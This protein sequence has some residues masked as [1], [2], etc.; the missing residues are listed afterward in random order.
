MNVRS[1]QAPQNTVGRY[2]IYG[3]FGGGVLGSV[4]GVLASG[5]NFFVWS[6]AQSIGVVAGLTMGMA[7]IG[8]FFAGLVVGD[9]AG[10]GA[11]AEGQKEMNSTVGGGSAADGADGGGVGD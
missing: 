11:S 8:Y 2:K 4:I 10:D 1:S 6:P 9:S 3:L 5:P 7:V